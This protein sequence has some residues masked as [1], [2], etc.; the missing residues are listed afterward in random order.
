MR[1]HHSK[2]TTNFQIVSHLEFDSFAP[3][4]K[5]K[6]IVHCCIFQPFWFHFTPICL[7][8]SEFGDEIGETNQNAAPQVMTAAL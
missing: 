3:D 7:L 5:A 6:E 2:N 8:W 4:L 1:V